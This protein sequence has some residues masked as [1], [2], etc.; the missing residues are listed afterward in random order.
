MLTN[1]LYRQWSQFNL[2]TCRI[3]L[4]IVRFKYLALDVLMDR[5]SFDARSN[6]PQSLNAIEYLS[7]KEFSIGFRDKYLIPLLSTLWSTNAGRFLPRLS[8]KTLAR[9]LHD[10]KL[11]RILKP[12][13]KWKYINISASQ[14]IRRMADYFPP[15]SVHLETRVQE[16]Q[17][18][19]KG[20]QTLI[21]ANGETVEFDHV[22]FAIDGEEILRLSQSAMN[23]EAKETL[24]DMWI[25]KN[26]AV[27]HS[28]PLVSISFMDS[29]LMTAR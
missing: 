4:D 18:A 26:I 20:K 3:M 15:G 13:P 8:I 14:F 10:H 23:A 25:I 29:L 28:D 5:P 21:M 27:L 16:V 22:I 12:E 2:E 7:Y 6:S 9:F 17:H 11:L 1:V 19:G 24:Q